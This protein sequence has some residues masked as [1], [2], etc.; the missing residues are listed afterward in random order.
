[1]VRM[2]IGCAALLSCASQDGAKR[3]DD[4]W[5]EAPA[6]EPE[7]PSDAEAAGPRGAS[8]SGLQ[9]QVQ[10][11]T[12]AL[13]E[14]ERACLA[15][16]PDVL[17]AE[18]LAE[19]SRLRIARFEAQTGPQVEDGAALKALNEVLGRVAPGKGLRARLT[20]S[21]LRR[22]GFVHDGTVL[23]TAGVLG[24]CADEAQLAGVLALA[25]ERVAR[26]ADVEPY[27]RTL[28]AECHTRHA[29]ARLAPS[30]AAVGPLPGMTLN[31]SGMAEAIGSFAEVEA[32]D[33]AVLQALAAAGYEP[34]AWEALVLTLGDTNLDGVSRAGAA[35][36]QA[37]RLSER[38][39][40]LKLK[41]GKRP[42]LAGALRR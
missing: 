20:R 6:Q 39:A 4:P 18:Q 24:A 26:R 35:Q 28:R 21:D 8:L 5:G 19:L 11:E 10:R 15:E 7:K 37:T 13:R 9:E 22:S 25:A 41:A 3:E 33:V 16:V 34:A 38:R 17:S 23:V 12:E 1:M 42:P 14:A 32:E 40:A 30:M 27:V 2:L 31:I 29:A 36:Q